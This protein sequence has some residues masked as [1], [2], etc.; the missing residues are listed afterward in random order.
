MEAKAGGRER[1]GVR[2]VTRFTYKNR[3]E[4]IKNTDTDRRKAL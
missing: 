3:R 4:H 1:G 2:R